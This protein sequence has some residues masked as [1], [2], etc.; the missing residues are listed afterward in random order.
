MGCVSA[1]WSHFSSRCVA[2][3]DICT[4][5]QEAQLLRL[6]DVAGTEDLT[7]GPCPHRVPSGDV[8]LPHIHTLPDT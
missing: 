6:E 7:L 3:R 8:A 1:T 5:H 4:G 2:S